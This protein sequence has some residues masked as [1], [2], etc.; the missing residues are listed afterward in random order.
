VRLA[1]ADGRHA[2]L[3]E[4]CA[5]AET[6]PARLR[7]LIGTPA[8]E[9][10]EGM[11][12][13]PAAA[14]HTLFMRFAIDVIFLDRCGR[15]VRAVE[16]LRP[17]RFTSRRGARAALELPAGAWRRAHGRVGDLVRY[18]PTLVVGEEKGAGGG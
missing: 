6:A 8:L 16:E 9:P 7:G 5:L 13:R 14:V 4:R 18:S 12:L 2:V 15:V 1:G 11:L 17:W 10:D 3:C